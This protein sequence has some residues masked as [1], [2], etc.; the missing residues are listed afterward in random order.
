M[1]GASIVRKDGS[2][3]FSTVKRFLDVAEA[4]GMTVYGHTLAW[5]SQQPVQYLNS[6]IEGKR[7]ELP[8]GETAEETVLA[9]DFNDGRHPFNGWGNN[10]SRSVEN[11]V[12]KVSNP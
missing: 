10:S 7:V 1:K 4:A 11:G 3:D 6:L 9:L 2:M 5:H 12:F 8:E